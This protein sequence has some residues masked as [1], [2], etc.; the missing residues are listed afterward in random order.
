MAAT[1]QCICG[2]AI[3]YRQDLTVDRSGTT[4]TW[5]CV[6]CGTPVPSGVAERIGHQYP[7]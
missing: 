2:K 6:D 4:R 7:S 5:A 3:R 1:H